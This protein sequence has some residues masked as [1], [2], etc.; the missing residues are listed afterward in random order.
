M[1][2]ALNVDIVSSNDACAVAAICFDRSCTPAA[3]IWP[4]F[5]TASRLPWLNDTSSSAVFIAFSMPSFTLAWVSLNPAAALVMPSFRFETV[6]SIPFVAAATVSSVVMPA[7]IAFG[8][9]LIMLCP[10][11]AAPLRSELGHRAGWNSLLHCSNAR[12]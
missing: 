5:S 2:I 10:C 9:M 6:A 3:Q 12:I 8:F 1:V 4:D 11:E 7:S